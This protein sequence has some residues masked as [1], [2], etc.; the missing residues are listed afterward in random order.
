MNVKKC[1]NVRLDKIWRN[2]AKICG[3]NVKFTLK[4]W[5]FYPW[6]YFFVP[7]LCCQKASRIIQIRNINFY[8][9]VRPPP[10]TQC[11]KIHPIWQR[12]ASLRQGLWYSECMLQNAVRQE[13]YIVV[14]PQ[15]IWLWMQACGS[16]FCDK[17]GLIF[18]GPRCPWSPI[19]GSEPMSVSQSVQHLLQT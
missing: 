19:Y 9:W 1:V 15:V 17:N 5:Q 16:S 11:V 2:S 10:F 8:T 4:L 3:Q 13:A 14:T 6:K 7:I 18:I 12:M